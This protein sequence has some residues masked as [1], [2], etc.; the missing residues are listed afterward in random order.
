MRPDV[1]LGQLVGLPVKRRRHDA[2][3]GR[4]SRIHL[5]DKADGRL[6]VSDAALVGSRAERSCYRR[7]SRRDRVTDTLPVCL[8]SFH[9]AS[10]GSALGFPAGR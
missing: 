10:N 5:L 4:R 9:L 8:D 2:D 7:G 6:D 3:I 1:L